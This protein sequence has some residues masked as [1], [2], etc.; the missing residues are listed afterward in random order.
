[1]G[2]I[3]KVQDL[4]QRCRGKRV[5]DEV[6]FTVS[7]G[8]FFGLFGVKGSGKTSLL[9]ILAGIDRFVSGSVEVL[10]FDAAKTE[11]FKK[12]LGLVTQLPSLFKDLSAG[13]NLDFL[14][15]LKGA[16]KNSV[17]EVV[18]RL[19]LEGYLKQRAGKMLPGPYG[20]LSLAC[21]MLGH[22]RLLL[23][24]EFAGNLDEESTTLIFQEINRFYKEGG[25]VVA[26]LTRPEFF[27]LAGKI[28]FLKEG[29][30]QLL[31]PEAAAALWREQMKFVAG[32]SDVDA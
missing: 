23:L 12:Y 27:C 1:V 4:V 31:E 7:E 5:L 14:A 8:E 26:V 20:R 15:A 30:M 19:N 9:H 17:Q 2:E 11:K 3:I 22:P 18:E 29:R 13:E 32:R 21:A 24:D 28:G 6:S 10:G 25:T 16:P